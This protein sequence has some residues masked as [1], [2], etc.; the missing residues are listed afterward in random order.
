MLWWGCGAQVRVSF[1]VVQR[2]VPL[3]RALLYPCLR[4]CAYLC[5]SVRVSG[6]TLYCMISSLMFLSSVCFSLWYYEWIALPYATSPLRALVR[7]LISLLYP[8]DGEFSLAVSGT[9]G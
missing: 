7:G 2:P 9:M 5:P 6:L 4:S 8:S 3:G 1:M